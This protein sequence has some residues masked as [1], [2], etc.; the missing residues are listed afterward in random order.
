MKVLL[1][2]YSFWPSVGGIETVTEILAQEFVKLNI[3]CKVVTVTPS[4]TPGS[5]TFPVVRNPRMKEVIKLVKW[6]DIILYNGVSLKLQPWPLLLRKPFIW[7]H[8]GYQVCCIDGLGWW[9][10]Q[11][12]PI[13]PLES[14]RFH[15]KYRG[16]RSGVIGMVKL[17]TKRFF[18]I[19][20]V[21]RNVAITEWMMETLN[22]PNQVQIYN[23]FPLTDYLISP[24]LTPEFD[25][26][27]LGRIVSEKGVGTLLHAFNIV[28]QKKN[29][30]SRLLI[31]GDGDHRSSMEKLASD[32]DISSYV[33][34]VGKKRGEKLHSAIATG[35]IAIVP[36]EWFEPMG[37][38]ALELMTA[39]KNLIVSEFG[40]L[41]ECV[42]DGGITFPNGNQNSLADRMIELLHDEAL[43]EEQLKKFRTT[44][45]KFEPSNSISQYITMLK[46]TI[47]P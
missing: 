33:S 14:I 40:G 29:F 43:R 10:N 32:L 26:I 31:I 12:A 5:F 46:A 13:T 36:S 34:F 7:I 8:A 38:V 1:F 23:P 22:L 39:G 9:Q 30:S 11:K 41:K 35:R 47:T 18:A 20:L 21:R 24:N 15:L 16:L 37:V 2:S 19:Y 3:E 17:A 28:L 25:F 42:G 44:V 27:Y 4:D 45:K 6:A